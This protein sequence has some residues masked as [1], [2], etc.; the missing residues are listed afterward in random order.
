MHTIR[1]YGVPALTLDGVPL[2]RERDGGFAVPADRA[3]EIA[4]AFSLSYTPVAAVEPPP[5]PPDEGD[6]EPEQQKAKGK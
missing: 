3:T 6:A 4:Q 2:K 5:S 1:L